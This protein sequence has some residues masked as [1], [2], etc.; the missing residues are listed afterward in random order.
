M[1][2]S[3]SPE[4]V[5]RVNLN[6]GPR[7]RGGAPGVADAGNLLTTYGSGPLR[8]FDHRALG[9]W[10]VLLL[11]DPPRE[12]AATAEGT[13]Q[14]DQA[15]GEA[16][17]LLDRLEDQL[18]RFRPESDV[19]LLGA[20]GAHKPVGIGTGRMSYRKREGQRS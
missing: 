11:A 14:V 18:S 17:A 3:S 4:R 10:N 12:A 1:I 5:Q 6:E 13:G 8:R 7:T 2:G 20:L 19:C 9:T 16:L 15:A